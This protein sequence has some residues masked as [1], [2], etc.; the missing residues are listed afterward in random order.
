[1]EKFEKLRF[2]RR[3]D[4]IAIIIL[5]ASFTA[6]HYAISYIPNSLISFIGFFLMTAIF[7]SFTALALSSVGAVIAF[8]T[9]A[10]IATISVPSLG[11]I[12]VLKIPAFIAAGLCFEIIF[13]LSKLE[14]KSIP[15]DAILSSSIANASIPLF[16]GI[17]ISIGLVKEMFAA[18]TNIALI[19][20]FVGIIGSTAAFL[21][22][23]EFRNTKPLLRLQYEA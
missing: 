11:L 4:L 15:M 21:L 14:I 5:V 20:F 9:L 7:I 13:I 6:L 23:L 16:T 19:G 18:I 22:W 2:L 3:I 10:S 1:M 17:F 12:G 8:L